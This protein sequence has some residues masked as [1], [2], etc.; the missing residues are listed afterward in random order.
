MNPSAEFCK[1]G[2]QPWAPCG[3]GTRY[4]RPYSDSVATRTLILACL[5]LLVSL[6]GSGAFAS[7]EQAAGFSATVSRL[8]ASTRA[9][10]TGV[11]WHP[12]CPVSLDGLRLVRLSFRGFD[13]KTHTGELVVNADAT[14]AIVAVFRRL[15][16]EHFPI[17]RM[18]RVDRFSG[19]DF[20]SIEADN[21]SSFNCRSATGST[22]W[23]NH[24][25]GHAIDV[26][27]IE[28]PY[29]Y[30]SGTSSH[31][32]S[33]PFLDR[34]R[35]RPGMAFD[36]GALVMAFAAVGWGWGGHWSGDRDY[37]HFSANGG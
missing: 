27:P 11:S 18:E 26:N 14:R 8:D 22:H 28:N 12:G 34:S 23:S 20:A 5:A 3:A 24:A 19:D 29:V 36:G 6:T 37:Q 25:Y 10:M 15:Y 9:S 16:R 7:V 35:H 30:G 4:G 31:A 13:G 17:R 2:R 32:A 33:A 1:T 21:T